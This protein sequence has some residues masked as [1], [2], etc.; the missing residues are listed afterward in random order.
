MT[1]KEFNK[2]AVEIAS[3]YGIKESNVTVLAGIFNGWNSHYTIQAWD[4]KSNKHITSR[5]PNPSSSISEFSN[6]IKE[7]FREYSQEQEDIDII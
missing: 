5:Q 2:Y 7:H 3:E 6:K 4:V 1:L